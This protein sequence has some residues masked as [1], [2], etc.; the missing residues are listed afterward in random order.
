M[1]L[2]SLAIRRPVA[3]AMLFLSIGLFGIVSLAGMPVALLP[4]V[5][6][7]RLVVWTT[8]SETGPVEIER[9]VTEPVEEALSAVP[10]VRR[11][12]SA[13]REGRSVV[14]LTFPWGADMEFA[15]LHVRERLDNTVGR[16]PRSAARPTILRV[17]PGAEPIVVAS[18]I[19]GEDASARQLDA[20]AGTVFKRRLEQLDGVGRAI[21]VGGAEREIVVEVD[22]DRLA[23][24]GLTVEAISGA[25]S[26]ANAAQ[27][28][29]TIR[30]GRY[31]Y[32]LRALGEFAAVDEIAATVVARAPGGGTVTVADVGSVR[33]TV[34]ERESAAYYDGHPSI[35]LLVYR[36][37]E[38]STIAAAESAAETLEALDARHP[39]VDLAVV[40]SQAGFIT[41]SISGVVWSLVIGGVLAFGVLF[42]FLRDPRW[43][44][45]IAL[46]IPL[47]V[48]TAVALLRAAGVSLNVMS[49]GGLALGVGMLVDNSIVV[50]ENVFRHRERGLAAGAA[51]A[52]GAREVQGAITASTLTTIGVFFPIL[53]V[54]GF[55]GALFG[56]LALAVAFSLIASLLVALTLLPTLAARFDRDE[57]ARGRLFRWAGTAWRPVGARIGRA[58]RPGLEAFE[59]GFT[60]F[61]ARYERTLAWSLDHRGTVLAW[62]G[63]ALAAA[64]LVAVFLPR[65]VLPEVDQGTF[66]A[67]IELPPGTPFERTEALTLRLDEWLRQRDGV[68]AVLARVGR[69]SEGE[70]VEAA[71]RGRNAA[72]LDVRLERHG[73][74]SREVM[75][76]LREA[77]AELPPGVLSL[78]TGAATEIGQVLG[79]AGADVQVEMRGVDL[80]ELGK[81]AERVEARLVGLDALVDVGTTYEAGHPELRLSLDRE[82]I[83]RHGLEVR[84]VVTVL[85]DRTR[86]RRA[87]GF[88]DFDREIPVVVRP[89]AA[90]RRDLDAVLD[91]DVDGVPLRLLVEVEETTA[92]AAVLREGQQRMV[93]V[94]AD[95][96]DGGLGAAIGAIEEAIED[97]PVPPGVTVGVGGGG[98][99]LR[100]SFQSLVFAFL[101][102]F[103]LVYLILAAQFESLVLPFVVLLAV[104][105]AVAGA[106]IGLGVTGLGLDTMSGIGIVVLIGIAVN[107]AIVK[108]DFIEQARAR[109]DDPRKAI[110]EAGRIRLRPIVMTS[111]T[112]ILGL[113]PLAIGIGG[114][115]ELRQPLAVAVIGGIVTSTALTLIALP[116]CYSLVAGWRGERVG[117]GVPQADRPA[118]VAAP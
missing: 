13:S 26:D 51:A 50:L 34:A 107:D 31:R 32:A 8:M 58:A 3:V 103:L 48:L 89:G 6:F 22:P 111:V 68:E 102:A 65:N 40:T 55:A 61:A 57:A 49:L 17:D 54:E 98:E 99:E 75:S 28:G 35:G 21:A 25:L 88:V 108:V 77:F 93:A 56:D 69:A 11:I 33:D 47:S 10:G 66:T 72:V 101:L 74:S 44:A 81:V 114:G 43:P 19:A 83:A 42:P 110:E 73:P 96:A 112:T 117:A 12:E 2:S 91:G 15:Q 84:R 118:E 53:Y 5:A 24:H 9:F 7:P 38:A 39:G 100:R 60:G 29:G 116:V 67:R 113:L 106:V 70:A 4:D 76:D 45:V 64:L 80:A 14:R 27:P 20:L 41:S 59:R 95:V 36:E 63:A 1:S 79:T 71:L 18:A 97:L 23:A 87:T 78:E 104:P 105:L 46:A 115:A 90:V 62:T 30:R 109:H 86:G 82:A 94:T 85:T 37:S 52:L 92:P 16:L